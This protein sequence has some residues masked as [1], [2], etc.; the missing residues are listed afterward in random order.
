MGTVGM[1]RDRSESGN[2]RGG[3]EGIHSE[4]GVLDAH[5]GR[6]LNRKKVGAI[7]LRLEFELLDAHVRLGVWGIARIQ[8]EG[9]ARLLHG[10]ALLAHSRRRREALLSFRNSC[11]NEEACQLR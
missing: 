10:P 7:M 11:I 6:I 3:Q 4:G 1:I 9:R 8:R 2:D 5:L